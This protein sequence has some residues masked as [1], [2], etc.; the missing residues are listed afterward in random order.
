[1]RIDSRYTCTWGTL[2][3]IY[4]SKEEQDVQAHHL[5]TAG[6]HNTHPA[7][8]GLWPTTAAT[9]ADP[10]PTHIDS[11]TSD[12]DPGAAHSNAHSSDTHVDPSTSNADA[13]TTYPNT[14]P[15]YAHI[16]GHTPHTDRSATHADT[17]STNTYAAAQ[18]VHGTAGGDQLLR[19]PFVFHHCRHHARGA[20][21]WPSVD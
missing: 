19:N 13:D 7:A 12:S 2:D 6:G 15:S 3:S 17:C 16:D 4:V 8:R 18:G 21:Q 5:P 10:H 9:H 11:G 1:V 20:R 14:H